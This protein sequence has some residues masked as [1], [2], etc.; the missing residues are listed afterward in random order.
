[1]RFGSQRTGGWNI[2]CPKQQ[3]VRRILHL[4][5]AKAGSGALMAHLKMPGWQ[6]TP[7]MFRVQNVKQAGQECNSKEERDARA[8]AGSAAAQVK[9]KHKRTQTKSQQNKTAADESAEKPVWWHLS[10]QQIPHQEVIQARKG[11]LFRRKPFWQRLR[12]MKRSYLLLN[13]DRAGAN[14]VEVTRSDPKLTGSNCQYWGVWANAARMVSEFWCAED[15][16]QAAQFLQGLREM[17][18][19]GLANKCEDGRGQEDLDWWMQWLEWEGLWHVPCETQE[20]I[21]WNIGPTAVELSYNH[22]THALSKRASVVMLQEVAFHPGEHRRVRKKLQSLSPDYWC[23]MERS[24][25]RRTGQE[26]SSEQPT[27]RNWQS[28]WVYAVVTFLHKDVFKKP[29]RMEWKG[30]Y[31]DKE[32]SFMLQGRVLWL[33]AP[34]QDG[35]P[36]MIVN[37]H[38]ASSKHA[39]LQQSVWMALQAKHAEHPEVKGIIGGDFN[40]NANGVR[41]GYSQSN[42]R[43][44]EMVDTQLQSFVRAIKGQLISPNR[45]SRKDELTGKAARLDHLLLLNVEATKDAGTVAW[46]GSPYHDHARVSYAVDIGRPHAQPERKKEAEA[47]PRQFSL[48]QWQGISHIVDPELKQAARQSSERLQ[49]GAGDSDLERRQMLGARSAAGENTIPLGQPKHEPRLPYRNAEQQRLLRKRC[50]VESALREINGGGKLTR[51]HLAFLHDLG[52]T[53][54]PMLPQKQAELVATPQWKSL[55]Q[56]ELRDCRNQINRITMKQIREHERRARQKEAKEFLADKKGPSHFMGK[57]QSN[58]PLERL[59][60]SAPTGILWIHNRSASVEDILLK[61]I[62]T[63]LPTA[64]VHQVSAI[65]VAMLTISTKASTAEQADAVVSRAQRMWKW[66]QAISSPEKYLELVR[67]LF[68][69]QAEPATQHSK[70]GEVAAKAVEIL[71]DSAGHNDDI[72]RAGNRG[73]DHREERSWWSQGPESAKQIERWREC[74]QCCNDMSKYE[75][76]AEL[77]MTPSPEAPGEFVIKLRVRQGDAEYSISMKNATILARSGQAANPPEEAI[78]TTGLRATGQFATD[79]PLARYEIW[80][81]RNNDLSITRVHVQRLLEW[82]KLA[83]ISQESEMQDEATFKPKVVIEQGPW[84]QD[85]LTVAW[86][87]YMQTEGLSPHVHCQHC[88][89]KAKPMVVVTQVKAKARRK[90]T[91][92]CTE[93]WQFTDK[94]EGKDKVAAMNFMMHFDPDK[95]R[96]RN[97]L[98]YEEHEHPRRIRGRVTDHELDQFRQHRLQLRKTGGPDG[99]NNEMFRVLTHEEMEILREWASRVLQDAKGAE[100][101]TEEVLNGTVRLL[102]KGGE[103]SDKPS[104]WRPI[105]LLN[106]SMQLV[107]HVI[108]SRLTEITEKENL[109]VPGQNGG[110]RQRGVDLN[111]TKLD[112]ITRE[113]KRLQQRFLRIDIDFKNAFNSMSQSALW[114]IMRAY[115]IPDVD[116]LESIYSKTTVRMHPNDDECASISFDTGVA[117]G[118]ALSPRLFILFMNALLEHLTHTGKAQGISHGIESTDQFNNLA[119]IDDATVLAQNQAGGQVLL[120]AIQEFEDWSGMKVNLSKTWVLDVDGGS[121]ETDLPQLEF[122]GQPVRLLDPTAS[123]RYLG[124]WATANGDMTATKERVRSK[125]K[126]ALEVL[127]H[128]PLEADV[129][130]ELFQCTA[131]SVFRFS[132]A[133]VP[134]TQQELDELLSLWTRAYKRAEGLPGGTATDIYVLSKEWGGK[135]FSTP[136]NII[137]QEL[138]NNI[139]RCLEHADTIRSITLQELQQAKE[140]WMCSSIDELYEEMELWTWDQT[141]CNK[142]ARALKACNQVQVKPTWIIDQTTSEPAPMSWA[143]ATRQLRKLKRRIQEVGGERTEPQPRAWQVKDN[144]QWELLWKGEETF[145]KCAA[146]LRAAGYH[147][148]LSLPQEQL[149]PR[150]RRQEKTPK[151]VSGEGGGA[152]H[153][154]ILV[155]KIRGI[156]EQERGTLQDWLGMVDWASM[157]NMEGTRVGIKTALGRAPTHS[158]VVGSAD[159]KQKP[160]TA[161][162]DEQQAAAFNQC[163]QEIQTLAEAIATGHTQVEKVRPTTT[164]DAQVT[165]AALIT[166]LKQVQVVQ[167]VARQVTELLWVSLGRDEDDSEGGVKFPLDVTIQQITRYVEERMRMRC[168]RCPKHLT[169][170]TYVCPLCQSKSCVTC[171]AEHG[172]TKCTNCQEVIP[173]APEQVSNARAKRANCVNMHTLGNQW[174]GKVTDVREADEHDDRT[175]DLRF[176]AHV[177]GWDDITRQ[178]RCQTLLN[179]K[180][181]SSLRKALLSDQHREILLIPAEWYEDAPKFETP[182]WWYAPAEE[183]RMRECRKCSTFWEHEAFTNAE[184]NRRGRA[185]CQRCASPE[186]RSSGKRS[187]PRQGKR[188]STKKPG[189]AG[190]AKPQLTSPD[191]PDGPPSE[192]R[193]GLRKRSHVMYEE[194][195]A[196]ED[197]NDDEQD[198]KEGRF[199]AHDG[200]RLRA[201]DPRYITHPSDYDRGDI[202]VPMSTVRELLQRKADAEAQPTQIWLTTAEMGYALR[203]DEHTIVCPKDAQEGKLEDRYLAPAIS[204]YI[205]QCAAD[206]SSADSSRKSQLLHQAQELHAKWGL[207]DGT[208]DEQAEEESIRQNRANPLQF[209]RITTHKRLR[210]E[211]SSISNQALDPEPIPD[212]NVKAHVGRDFLLNQPIPEAECGYVRVTKHSLYWQET[213]YPNV[214]TAEGIST[215]M[216]AGYGWHINSSTWRHLQAH[217][218]AS[219]QELIQLVHTE[220]NH[221]NNIEAG[222]YRSPTWRV[223]KALQKINNAQ[224]IIGESAVSAAPCFASAG[225]PGIPFWG[226]QTGPKLI[227]WDSLTDEEK[228]KCE[229]SMQS[230]KSWVVWCRAESKKTSTHEPE[231]KRLGKRIFSSSRSRKKGTQAELGQEASG[232]HVVRARGWWKRGDVA[233]CAATCKMECWTHSEANVNQEQA[234]KHI[235]AAWESED[236]KD[237]LQIDLTGLEREYWLGTEAGR[238]GCYEFQGEVWAGDGSVKGDSMGAGSIRYQNHEHR[239]AVRVGR[240]EE[241]TNSLRTELAAIASVL[242]SASVREDLL[243]LGD[244]ETALDRIRSWIGRGPKA[245]LVGD[246]NADI[247]RPIIECLRVRTQQGA[248][249]FFVKIKAHRG[250]PLNECADTQAETARQLPEDTQQWTDRTRRMTY[251]WRDKEVTRTSTWS[252]AVRNA[253]RRGAAEWHRK[254]ILRKAAGKWSKEFCKIAETQDAQGLRVIRHSASNGPQGII[255]DA[256]KWDEMCMQQLQEDED[257]REPAATTWAAEFLLRSNESREFLGSWMSSKAT[258]EG[259]KRRATQVI[260]CSFPCRKW[261]HMIY[262]QISPQCELCRRDRA[263]RGASEDRLP[264]ESVAHIQSAGCRAQKES[265][266]NAHNRCWQYLLKAIQEH[267]NETRKLD[268]IGDDKDKQLATLWAESKIQDIVEWDEL[269]LIADQLIAQKQGSQRDAL[270]STNDD[271]E[272]DEDEDRQAPYKEVVFEKRRPDSMAIDWT[273]KKIYVLEFKRTSDQ[274]SNYRSRAEARAA[275]QHDVLIKSLKEV[276]QNR[277]G[278]QVVWDAKLITFVGGTCGSVNVDKFNEH[279]EELQVSKGKYRAIRKGL[280]YELLHAQD[281]VLCSYFAQRNGHRG[282]QAAQGAARNDLMHQLS[283]H[284]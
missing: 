24:S 79:G 123:C 109:I 111:Q 218:S 220:M 187:R 259:A 26:T 54:T 191:Q 75:D 20:V 159:R 94:H 170:L 93:C 65:E 125:T 189:H 30:G 92:F 143:A 50:R 138:C 275:E 95:G 207:C 15:A 23:N 119:F 219:P 99:T 195:H 225:R 104:D 126:E 215:C 37:I 18:K 87:Q 25:R 21:T 241:G 12:L 88:E 130:R 90:T 196:S 265:V 71:W 147:T 43:H 97:A 67:Q 14:A 256:T 229:Q 96:F 10:S 141:R 188:G 32:L 237:T 258:H 245:S 144:L 166:W 201:A 127:T 28:N 34:R 57:G 235:K 100:I 46:V 269:K 105:V 280:V 281:K 61:R 148:I 211:R 120:D 247:M 267:G 152:Q 7:S 253:M 17:G 107:Y 171:N 175:M 106:V 83:T 240:A 80:V 257:R 117:Q 223:L 209:E 134:W 52:L 76:P 177:R 176:K 150:T 78:Q 198:D 44:L 221:Q 185:Q 174:I 27:A 212:C 129:A 149:D 179:L 47:A 205:R 202:L 31:K 58:V 251:E 164:R 243:Y 51:V 193:P 184:W 91:C 1:M 89:C 131:I 137:A 72:M 213:A 204:Q 42:A 231:F 102:H 55:L 136:T 180:S 62:R 244:S 217:S 40:A 151:L 268:F 156:S 262:P 77:T 19:V 271:H 250:E 227:L 112:W 140:S 110:R 101:L 56:A 22:I 4:L 203:E 277:F 85:N 282:A 16:N 145:W 118:S 190:L 139:K 274:R 103:T 182:G 283:K 66:Q 81:G 248:R 157:G 168:L 128:H 183:V 33:W 41:E 48:E 208:L 49:H 63:K 199:K 172:K 2:T 53:Q 194:C 230:E 165:G 121:G 214:V 98:K 142:W 246:A 122:K 70:L 154:R 167:P 84:E 228:T 161:E 64:T 264:M 242:Q 226:P 116:L 45:P 200:L 254:K 162:T 158:T 86:E 252:N 155:P 260:T 82:E 114:A 169:P 192:R 68:L 6:P 38:Q 272:Q 216:E 255:M 8:R 160:S 186:S 115:N 234:F 239:R 3:V 5:H 69:Q 266:I 36:M 108:N 222:K 39:Q 276:F 279:L 9:C 74:L 210:W 233:A 132:A 59:K 35:T 284:E 197:E 270:S 278:R 261:L 206:P 133:Q 29:I 124:Y 146:A 232:R 181:D 13:G 249:T 135:C 153:F 173:H 11:E 238:L 60:L 113:A 273:N 224:M 263:A 236:D 178:S 163:L 73:V